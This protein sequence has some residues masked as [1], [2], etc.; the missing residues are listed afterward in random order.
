MNNEI[1]QIAESLSKGKARKAFGPTAS[2]QQALMFGTRAEG[3]HV[4]VR[5]R[6]DQVRKTATKLK[7]LGLFKAKRAKR[8][9][10]GTRYTTTEKGLQV[11]ELLQE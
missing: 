5:Y 10:D 6:D 11:L 9:G 2:D 8:F 3:F 4:G 1:Q 7:K